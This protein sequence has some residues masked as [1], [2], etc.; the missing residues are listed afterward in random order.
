MV[1]T[2]RCR[3]IGMACDYV[4]CGSSEDEVLRKGGEHARLEHG[5]VSFSPEEQQQVKS[6]I[7]EEEQC[8]TSGE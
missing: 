2:L 5:K 6:A 7:R 8:P 1:K 4:A 3:D